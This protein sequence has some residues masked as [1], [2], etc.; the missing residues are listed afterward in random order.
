MSRI[1]SIVGDWNIQRHMNPTNCRDRPLMSGSEVI[2]CGKLSIL[3][4]ALKSVREE[5]T[6]CVVSC[7]SNFLTGSK[8]AGS[9]VSPRIEPVLSDFCKA[10]NLASGDRSDIIYLVSAP[11][12]MILSVSSAVKSV[13]RLLIAWMKV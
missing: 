1:F 2:P 8:S 9:T 11:L 7:V 13:D 10:L 6:I 5:S 3:A 4:E 12:W